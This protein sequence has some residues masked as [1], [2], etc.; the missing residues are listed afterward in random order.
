M[1]TSEKISPEYVAY[2]SLNLKK[3]SWQLLST[4]DFVDWFLLVVACCTD[5]S[6]WSCPSKFHSLNGSEKTKGTY[7][8]GPPSQR[9]A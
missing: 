7:L 8:A 2:Q 3:E 9:G 6:K 1:T 4:L 5:S